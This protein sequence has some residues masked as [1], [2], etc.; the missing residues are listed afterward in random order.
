MSKQVKL[1]VKNL[2]TYFFTSEGVLPAVDCVSFTVNSG[3]KVAIVG[4][5]GCG[6]SVTCLSIMRLIRQPGKIVG[7]EVFFEGKD[8]LKNSEQKMRKIRGSKISMIFQEPVT[9][10]NPVMTC[11]DQIAESFMLHRGL[12]R[13]DALEK[14]VEMLKLVDISAPE[15][16]VKEYPFQLSGG[17]CQRVMIAMALGCT[18][19]ILI[20]DEPTTALDVTVQAQILDLI[21]INSQK[22]QMSLLLITHDIA[23]AFETVEKIIVMYGGKVVEES[24][25]H[26]IAQQPLHP[27]TEGLL[28]SIP[29]IDKVRT[30]R[31]QVIRGIVPSP[32]DLPSGCTFNPRCS[33]VMDIC[34]EEQPPLK[35]IAKNH[36][37]RC[38]LRTPY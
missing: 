10:L 18:P 2:S 33:Y 1:D 16:R 36:S 9:S 4:E 24:D 21:K 25:V 5:S 38:W 7:G 29:S 37:V 32:L 8:L 19:E 22:L 27:Y 30:K 31:L 35:V 14:A 26:T 23:M 13:K 34:K 15:Q 20:A 3:E 28:N 12:S 6:K 11:G 17:M